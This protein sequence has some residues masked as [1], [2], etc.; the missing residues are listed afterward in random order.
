MPAEIK[1]HAKL[2][3][4]AAVDE[5]IALAA[6]HGGA[7]RLAVARGR[8]GEYHVVTAQLDDEAAAEDLL[9]E[10]ADAALGL[11]VESDRSS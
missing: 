9:A 10:I 11:T 2:Y 5:A 6:E 4:R 1:L 7:A 8:D 3:R